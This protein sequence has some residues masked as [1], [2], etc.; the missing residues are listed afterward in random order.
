MIK[1]VL[2][3]HGE[4]TWNKENLF[5]GW[6]DVDLSEKG[7]AEAKKG[8][9]LLK[10]GGYTFDIAYTSVLKRA[11]K[12]L[13]I[14]Q[15]ELDLLCFHG[16]PTSFDDVI[17]PAAPE[18]EFHKFLIPEVLRNSELSD[19]YLAFMEKRREVVRRVLRRGMET[20]ELRPDLDVNLVQLMLSG[21]LVLDNMSPPAGR[22][23]SE[24]LPERVVDTILSGI[25]CT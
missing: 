4:S 2:I 5:T 25:A 20:G 19:R 17:L 9:E 24:Q 1:L 12:T 16:S 13:W 8:G 23:D 3:R 7:L 18:E 14:V 22:I 10:E 6:T 15:N 21:P 11:I